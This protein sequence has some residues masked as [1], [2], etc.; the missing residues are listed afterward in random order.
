MSTPLKVLRHLGLLV[1]AAGTALASGQ[2]P[3]RSG[4]PALPATPPA[5]SAGIFH[6]SEVQPGQ[7]GVAYTVFQGVIPEPM[8]VEILGVLRNALGPGEDM[9]LARLSGVK[10]EYTGVVAGMS[11]SPVYIDGRLA[12]A[13]AFRIGQ[14]SKEPIA[15]I[16]PIERMLEVRDLP[17]TPADTGQ[18]AALPYAQTAALAPNTAPAAQQ[19]GAPDLIRAM[20]TPLVFSGFSP[21]A[22]ALW[23]QQSSVPGLEPVAGLGGG[24]SATDKQPEPLIPGSA[25]SALLVEGDLEIAATCTVTYID[26]KHL[27]ACGHPITQFGAVSMPMTKANVVATL[28]SPLNAFKIV[29]TTEQV[30]SFTEDRQTAIGGLLGEPARMIPVTISVADA[31]SAAAPHVLRLRVLDQPQLTPTAVLVSVFQ[32][33]SQANAAAAQD[34]YRLH[35]SIHIAG[36][37]EVRL[38]NLAAPSDLGP[39]N[40]TAAL[41]IGTRFARLYDN[42]GRRA[43]IQSVELTVERLHEHLTTQLEGAEAERTTVHPGQSLTLFASVRPW[44]G[45]LVTMP[46]T[47]TL[48]ASLPGG[49]IRLLVSDGGTLDRLTQ[50]PRGGESLDLAGTIAQLNSLHATDRL[51]VTL[52]TG[53]AQ[54]VV[55]GRLLASLPLSMTNVYEPLRAEQKVT[56]NGESLLQLASAPAGAE[57][58][59]QQVIALRVE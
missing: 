21:A 38:D 37:P 55:E 16:T 45:A 24:G 27:L 54:A 39:A 20:D 43:P 52:L 56:L 11:G 18:A 29:N 42:A 5:S 33:L 6:L 50:S 48:P 35:G 3:E 36:Y 2:Q 47:V 49:P 46:I 25:V 9:I 14:F 31:G 13:L 4:E 40:L 51:Y 26:A 30:G 53:D 17:R 28:P 34:S 12:G 8:G 59:G 23:R 41:G 57:L 32:G 44:H 22:L 19:A 58:S 15:G 7:H 10:A 1:L